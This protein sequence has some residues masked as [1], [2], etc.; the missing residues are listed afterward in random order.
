MQYSLSPDRIPETCSLTYRRDCHTEDE[1]GGRNGKENHER[2]VV[3]RTRDAADSL[4]LPLRT[5]PRETRLARRLSVL[6]RCH[7]E[8]G[9]RDA[10]TMKDD[11]GSHSSGARV[12]HRVRFFRDFAR[13]ALVQLRP[14][15]LIIRTAGYKDARTDR[16]NRRK[17][18]NVK[19]RCFKKNHVP[20]TGCQ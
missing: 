19:M 12:L 6:V 10:G 16:E 3:G 15:Q 4:L 9:E 7:G 5:L 17:K 8:A 1:N 20:P 2:D 18:T 14:N 13:F 11:R